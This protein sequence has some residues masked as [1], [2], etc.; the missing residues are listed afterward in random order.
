LETDGCR[1]INTV[2]HGDKAYRYPRYQ[3]S[4]RSQDI[5]DLFC[6]ACDQI[7]VRWRVM[8]AMNISVARRDSVAILDEF[9][10]PKR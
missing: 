3:F 5:K 7:G 6:A 2:R 10:G 8:N 1:A 9:V 4:N